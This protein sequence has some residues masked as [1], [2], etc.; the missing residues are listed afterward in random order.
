MLILASEGAVWLVVCSLLSGLLSSCTS[1]AIGTLALCDF[2]DLLA[3]DLLLRLA[4]LLLL[5]FL[6]RRLYG[7]GWD[8]LAAILAAPGGVLTE[9]LTLCRYS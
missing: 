3:P 4:E 7:F 6:I 2:Y 1:G 8:C 5:L 9:A